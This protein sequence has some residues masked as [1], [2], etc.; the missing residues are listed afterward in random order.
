MPRWGERG[1]SRSLHANHAIYDS[2]KGLNTKKNEILGKWVRHKIRQKTFVTKISKIWFLLPPVI[3]SIKIEKVSKRTRRIDNLCE[4]AFFLPPPPP[5]P[6]KTAASFHPAVRLVFCLFCSS[7][8]IQVILFAKFSRG[9]CS[10]RRRSASDK[11]R[12]HISNYDIL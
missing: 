3:S 7:F 5:L 4:W 8:R 6:R 9:R 11:Y 12:H 1:V 10:I 2:L